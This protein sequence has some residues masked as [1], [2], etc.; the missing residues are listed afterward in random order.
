MPS[1]CSICCHNL[2]VGRLI[3]CTIDK[4]AFSL[5]RSRR[6][7]YLGRRSRQQKVQVPRKV[8]YLVLTGHSACECEL[9]LNHIGVGDISQLWGKTFC[10]KIM[11]EKLTNA[12]IRRDIRPKN[13]QNA[14]I[15]MIFARKVNK[16]PEL[17]TIF[18]R[19]MPEFYMV[20][21]RKIFSRFLGG[22]GHVFPRHP[23]SYAY[24]TIRR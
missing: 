19:K 12:R 2:G 24:A 14:R 8:A 15:F 4:S 10:M 22:R 17:Y 21:A 7:R 16:I 9:S 11:Y 23:V 3:R 20:I 13:Y 6:C 5:T 1:R 18:A